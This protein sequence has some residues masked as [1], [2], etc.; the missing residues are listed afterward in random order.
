MDGNKALWDTLIKNALVF[1]G[2]GSLPQ[3][4]DVAIHGGRIAAVGRNLGVEN[5]NSVMDAQGQWLMPG[6]LDIHTHFD[7]EV[8]LE[9]GLPEAVRHGTTTAVVANCS[10]GIAYGA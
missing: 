6:M 8:E 3:A 5:A 9:P 2:S 7:L 1:D 10:L 4:Q